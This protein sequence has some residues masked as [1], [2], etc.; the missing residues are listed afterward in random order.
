MINV[1]LNF[2]S[3]GRLLDEFNHLKRRRRQTQGEHGNIHWNSIARNKTID[4]FK[5]YHGFNINAEKYGKLSEKKGV[6]LSYRSK[7]RTVPL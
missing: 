2:C 7:P 3:T 6:S 4:P 1:A 5:V